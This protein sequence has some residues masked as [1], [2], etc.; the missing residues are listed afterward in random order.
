MNEMV[1]LLIQEELKQFDYG[2]QLGFGKCFSF[3]DKQFSVSIQNEIGLYN[4]SNSK[5][6]VHQLKISYL[7]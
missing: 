1:S 6:L 7:L 4:F 3:K 2:L 5:N